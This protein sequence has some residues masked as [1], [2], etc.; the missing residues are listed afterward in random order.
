MAVVVQEEAPASGGLTAAGLAAWRAELANLARDVSDA[1]RVDQ[2]RALEELK[3]AAC[4][5]Q[6]QI[7]ADL[8]ASIRAE[9]ADRGI[10]TKDRGKGIGAQ[11]A[12]AR[13]ESPNRGGRLLGLATA[14][15]AEMPHTH[16][17]LRAGLIN[18][19]RATLLVRESAC[20]TVD[21]RRELDAQLAADP[22]ALEQWGDRELVRRAR[23]VAYRIDATSVVARARKAEGE[24]CVTL[25]PAPDTMSYLTGL[26]PV[27]QGVGV[28]AALNKA[29]DSLR[30]QGDPRSRGQLMA[31]LLVERVTGQATADAV[32]IEI[33]LVMT[34]RTLLAGDD[35]PAHIPGYGTVPGPWARKLV[36]GSAATSLE[37]AP[38]GTDGHGP[39]AVLGGERRYDNDGRAPRGE[40]GRRAEQDWAGAPRWWRRLYTHPTSGQL[41]AMESKRRTAPAGLARFIDARDQSCRSPWCDAPVRHHDHITPHASGGPTSAHNLEGLCE[42]CNYTKDAPDWRARAGPQEA[43]RHLMEIATPTGHRYHSSSPPLPGHDDADPGAAAIVQ[44]DPPSVGSPGPGSNSI[45][46]HAPPARSPDPDSEAMIQLDATSITQLYAPPARRPAPATPGDEASA[47]ETFMAE[48]LAA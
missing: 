5:A 1:E 37:G 40:E 39:P 30:A 16:A 18:E 31:D 46:L 14:L 23:Q 24:R 45:Q 36:A 17:A 48:L 21:Q 9:R 11:V 3:A 8:D 42:A 27:A 7:A 13:R 38:D 25:R 4:A 43:G 15:V 12:L 10:P 32:P 19:W 47:V 34:D 2:L 26:L 28:L 33:Q 20:L 22:T 35:T 41:V 29:A 44:S 6:A